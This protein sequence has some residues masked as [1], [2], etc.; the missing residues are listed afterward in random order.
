MI[1]SEQKHQHRNN[2]KT[3]SDSKTTRFRFKP[4]GKIVFYMILN[5]KWHS[6]DIVVKISNM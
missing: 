2:L 4:K 1:F 3:M 5:L 6:E